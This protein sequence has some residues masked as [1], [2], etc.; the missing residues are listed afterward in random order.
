M[1]DRA[2]LFP[3][4]L[5]IFFFS[6]FFRAAPEAYGSFQARGQIRAT[7]ASLGHSH[8][9]AWSKPHVKSTPQLHS[10]TGLLTHWTRP[11]IKP[12]PS[13]QVGFVTT[14]SQQELPHMAFNSCCI[15]SSKDNSIPIQQTARFNYLFIYLFIYLVKWGWKYFLLLEIWFLRFLLIDDY[16]YS[17][18]IWIYSSS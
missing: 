7:A 6:F 16:Q 4:W 18:K 8:S 14:E 9:N 17:L 15:P 11:E 12:S 1:N 3:Q 5:L 13:I 10:N 2:C